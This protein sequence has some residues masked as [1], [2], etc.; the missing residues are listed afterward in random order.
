[1]RL[2]V[3]ERRRRWLEA[4]RRSQARYPEKQE[5]RQQVRI[6]VRSGA[7]VRKP[8]EVCGE[9]KTEAHHEDYSKP[10]EVMWLCHVHHRKQHYKNARPRAL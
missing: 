7:M 5:A 10:L 1:M 9:P 2:T 3:E 6:A 4:Q 8:C